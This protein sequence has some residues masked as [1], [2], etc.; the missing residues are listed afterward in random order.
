M[1]VILQIYAFSIVQKIILLKIRQIQ[2]I[3]NVFKHAQNWDCHQ[4]AH[5]KIIALSHILV[6]IVNFY[7]D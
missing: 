7:A 3:P 5:A 6:M 4:L 2:Q 1:L